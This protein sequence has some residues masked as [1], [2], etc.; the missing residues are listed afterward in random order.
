MNVGTITD[1]RQGGKRL[2]IAPQEAREA[3]FKF[4]ERKG[5][6]NSITN[7]KIFH[8][9]AEVNFIRLF[10]IQDG[11]TRKKAVTFKSFVMF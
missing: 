10:L 9:F 11:Y 5:I 4:A 3:I 7:I 6:K 2:L 1:E 8:N